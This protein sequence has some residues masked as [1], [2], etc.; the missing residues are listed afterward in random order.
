MLVAAFRATLEEVIEA[1]VIL[2]VRDV[3]HED[4]EAQQHDVEDVLRQLG[5]D[6]E[7]GSRVIEVWNKID[8]LSAA[9]RER[10]ANLAER[11]EA[12]QRPVPVSAITGEGV[13]RLTDAIEARI[14]QT[15]TVIELEIDGGRRRRHQLATPEHRSTVADRP[16][17]RQGRDD[18]AGRPGQGRAGAGEIRRHEE[19]QLGEVAH[20]A[21]DR[22][23]PCR[24][25]CRSLPCRARARRPRSVSAKFRRR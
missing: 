14:A 1:D 20:D 22:R 2:H 23:R 8:R 24:A 13:D 25:G 12:K 11:Q 16:R 19:R 3:S 9:D 18:R 6:S 4:A 17:R 21:P 15:R 10:L 7:Q 5:V